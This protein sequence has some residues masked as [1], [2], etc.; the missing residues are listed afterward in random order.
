MKSTVTYT[1]YLFGIVIV[2]FLCLGTSL[3]AQKS[4][5]EYKGKVM[6]IDT[7]EPL[8]FVNLMVKS[9]NV[10]T[11]SNTEGEFILKVTNSMNDETVVVSLLGYNQHE[12]KLR[13]L[14]GGNGDIFLSKR[15]TQLSEV[16]LTAF[17]SAAALVRKVF[18]DKF[19]N[20]LDQSVLMTA[21]YRETIKKR[22]RN[23]SLTEAV[24]YVYKQPYSSA[25]KDMIT[26]HKARK[27]TDYRRLD[28]VT[29]KLQGGPFSAVY[30]DIMKYPEYIFTDTTLGLYN[31][32][33]DMP[34]TVN[35]RPVY[36][37]KF[38]QKKAVFGPG[39][40]G[41]LY[42]E[43]E[44]LALVSAT[45]ALNIVD[46]KMASELFVRKKPRDVDVTVLQAAYRVDYREKDGKWYYGYG[47]VQLAFKVNKKRK[48]FN[49]VYTLSSEMAVTDWYINKAGFKPKPKDRLRP[50]VII[51]DAISGF[52]DPDFWGPFNVIEPEKSIQSAIDKIRRKI[53]RANR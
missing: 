27:N 53:K 32:T 4:Y 20:T 22:N 43:A 15:I 16:N 10:S 30:V 21:F 14:A 2:G 37:V 51:A 33:F 3:N 46:S 23:V 26:L 6:D 12:L 45:Y 1:S 40:Q 44:S 29:L 41:K 49:S 18:A 52:S 35:D 24:V 31:F 38:K 19:N 13:I 50:T 36:V 7:R 11:I 47:S 28:T 25:R 5:T 34:S 39:Y 42:I 9:T 17:K 48:L 8:V